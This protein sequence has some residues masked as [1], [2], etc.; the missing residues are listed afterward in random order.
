MHPRALFPALTLALV[1]VPLGAQDAPPDTTDTDSP[2]KDL[3]LEAGRT[4]SMDFTEGSWISVD[5]SPDGQTLVFDYMGDLFT[6]P[7][8]GGEATPLTSG[9]AFDAQPRFSPDGSRVVFT[10]DRDGA[11]NIWILTLDG[12]DPV[13]I[14][15]GSANRAESPEWT[16]DGDYVVASIGG[17]RG[18]GNPT[19]KLFHV[20][21][22]SGVELLSNEDGAPKRIGAALGPD[23]RWIWYAE[24]TGNRDWDY[25]AQLPLYAIRAYDRD[26]GESYTRVSRYGGA[27]R[28]TLSPDGRWLVYGTRHDEHTGLV[29]RDLASGGER[30]LAHPVQ[31]DDQ[32]S[33]AALDALPGMSFTPD[34]RFLVASWGGRI[35]QVP[36]EGGDAEEIPFRVSLDLEVGPLVEFDYPILDTP[37][38]VVRQIRDA[39]PSPDDSRLAFT[40]LD[41]LYVSEADGSS[42]RALAEMDATQQH[43]A[44]SPDGDWIA[45]TTWSEAE[46]E[47]HL[48]KIRANGR[49][50]TRLSQ[51][52]GVYRDP[53]WS[54][55]GERIVAF[56]GYARD[57]LETS[58]PGAA[59]SANEV[60]WIPSQGG[61]ATLIVPGQGRAAP[62]FTG[63]P[64]RI[65]FSASP[66]RLVSL[67]WD[68][69]DEKT[70]IRVRGERSPGSPQ[71]ASPTVVVMAPMGDQ[72]MALIQGQ[73]YTVTVPRVGDAPTVNVGDPSAAAF[74]AKRLTRFGGEFPAWS[75]SG[76]RVHWSLGNAHFVYDLDA[77]EAFEEAADDAGPDES[78][79]AEYEPAEF[80]IRIETER[81][82][83]SGVLALTNARI[84]TMR[85][86]EVIERGDVVVRDNRIEEVGASGAV[87]IPEGAEV[88]DV[89][90]HTIV[91]GF[92]D[93]HAHMWPA[94]EIHR[95][96]QWMYWA[97]LAYGVT[98][99]RD[100]QTSRTDVLTYADL[101]RAGEIVGPRIYS[102][103]PGVFW[104]DNISSLEEARDLLRRYADYYDTKTLKMY[105]AGTRK[106]RQ[107]I[108]QAAR[109]LEIMPTT[110]GSLNL[111]Q[112]ITET[113]DGYPG[114]EHSIPVYPLYED[115]VRLFAETKRAYTPT[116]LVSYGG[117]WAENYYY[118][119]MNPHDDAKLRRFMPHDQV[120]V[121]TRRRGGGPS[122]GPAGWFREEEHVFQD[123]AIFARDLIEAG[124]R[125]GIGSHG[126]L[127]GLGYH[128]ELWS[129]ASG[130]MRPLDALRAS[131][132]LGA[133]ALG[134]DGDL[135]S[136]EPGKLADLVILRDNPLDDI[137]NTNS[138][139]HVMMNGRLY[140]G[141]T[142]R[143]IHPRRRDLPTPWWLEREPVGVPGTIR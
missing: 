46:G 25:N 35:W 71:A 102:T 62:H 10:S 133:E 28:P 1:A 130:G 108:I 20:D 37:T 106:Q 16:P 23:S 78:E 40:A 7:I 42:V 81:D 91:P 111:K 61:E 65:F 13:R 137:T 115:M 103:G 99:T 94:W 8:T 87:I 125:V 11:Q 56:R 132:I 120:D 29:L 77:A 76:R 123:H 30:W 54:P 127:Q 95:R 24:R 143:E 2:G 98:T 100:P 27:I 97:N 86:D 22:G 79:P 49:D 68:G 96:D 83:P 136:V 107:W 139:S 50:L 3:P 47:G 52:G 121:A 21:G 80:R 70:H 113:L 122:P 140:E 105:V 14:S 104:Q 72:A 51:R 48:F 31:K 69:S 141:D 26:T 41:R 39:V 4:I 6:L 5:V 32:E 142:L 117:P 116:L 15:S 82:L 93:T 53:V 55:D 112:N 60:V 18:G 34:S 75:A 85:G 66:D 44:W 129:V 118:T 33:R 131:T 84:V 109:E 90:G 124:G 17:F 73:I 101:V 38:F 135:G 59:G 89:A 36:L 43:P 12:S 92:V 57:Y 74:P 19:L 67:R 63:D 128:W 114:L 138:V 58:G 88:I 134:L 9:M 45:F 126:Q 119:R 64:D 110:E